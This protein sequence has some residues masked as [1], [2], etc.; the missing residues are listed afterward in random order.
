MK[1]L[2][3]KI[4][5]ATETGNKELVKS[6]SELSGVFGVEISNDLMSVLCGDKMPSDSIG[7]Y[8]SEQG[9]NATKV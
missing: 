7:T 3:Y 8:I 1:E 9:V 6:L 2:K 4:N 5:N